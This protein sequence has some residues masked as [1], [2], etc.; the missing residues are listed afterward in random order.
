MFLTVQRLQ[1]AREGRSRPWAE[2]FVQLMSLDIR[3]KAGFVE[4]SLILRSS[5]PVTSSVITKE[6]TGCVLRTN[7]T[8]STIRRM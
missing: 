2:Q 6:S 8:N 5:D 4:T 3:I 7:E 1:D